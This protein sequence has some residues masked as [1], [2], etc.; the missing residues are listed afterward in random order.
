V[1]QLFDTPLTFLFTYNTIGASGFLHLATTIS[2]ALDPH[3]AIP[4]VV[5]GTLNAV[6]AAAKEPSIKRFVLTSSSTA[7]TLPKPNLKFDLDESTWNEESIQKAWAPPP[8]TEERRWD[9]YGASKTE[10]ERALWNFVKEN[11]PGFVANAGR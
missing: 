1:P 4:T 6:K 2:P 11:K 8:Y 7:A 5:N 10:G 3:D 9:V